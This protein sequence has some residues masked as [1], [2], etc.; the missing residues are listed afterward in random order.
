ML[1]E[2]KQ[3]GLRQFQLAG[4]ALA[5]LAVGFV[6]SSVQAMTGG[7]SAYQAVTPED[8]AVLDQGLG[9]ALGVS[10][11]PLCVSKQIVAGTNYRFFCIA[12]GATYPP[13]EKNAFIDV[14]VDLNRKASKAHITEIPHEQLPGGYSIFKPMEK[15]DTEAFAQA[16]KGLVGAKYVPFAVS[17]QVVNGLNRKFL[18][19][20]Q[21][22]HLNAGRRNAFV[23]TFSAPG[24]PAIPKQIFDIESGRLPQILMH[25][26]ASI[27]K[28]SEMLT[29]AG[30]GA[31][32]GA[33]SGYKPLNADSIEAN[34]AQK[35]FAQTGAF[36]E[37]YVLLC[38]ATQV[39]AGTN[40]RFFCLPKEGTANNIVVQTHVN[41]EGA[42]EIQGLYQAEVDLLLI[43]ANQ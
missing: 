7:W 26:N 24:R 13:T 43:P 12:T 31:I 30:V 17:T 27:E 18:C 23:F 41:L 6:T 29:V 21:G 25:K 8:Q 22:M 34:E 36:Y 38:Y 3:S 10:Y 35:I 37:N 28:T 2:R 14:F 39:V 42:V 19:G 1:T 20:M 15:E 32:A 16:M 9:G 11:E 5:V 4:I 33:W 40:Y